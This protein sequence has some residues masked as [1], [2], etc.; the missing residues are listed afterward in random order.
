MNGREYVIYLDVFFLLN[1]IVAY[2]IILITSKIIRKTVNKS[3]ICLAAGLYGL[4]NVLILKPLFIHL[5]NTV[6]LNVI[7]AA[8]MV[9]IAF[10]YGEMKIYFR[11]LLMTI[12]VS[13]G[14]LGVIS[15]LYYFTVMGKYTR[16]VLCGSTNRVVNGRR[17]MI[18]SFM[19][20]ILLDIF[21][22]IVNRLRK[23]ESVYF[24]VKLTF[25]G[26]SVVA[27]ALYDT[28]NSLIEPVSKRDVHVAEYGLLKPIMEGD[29]QLEEK[30]CVIPFHSLG[31]ERG[32]MYGIRIDEMV[33]IYEGKPVFFNNPVIGIYKGSVSNTGKY[34][35][36]LNGNI[37]SKLKESRG[38]CNG[39]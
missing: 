23:N 27:K 8:V 29:E 17:F 13:A 39:S 32:L 22:K 14:F 2:M 38:D 37:D 26:K 36:I 6:L 7:A 35:V 24:D 18:S 20:Y 9:V 25:N 21:I 11:N 28:G 16:S 34:S 30:I 1:F 19:A 15:Y 33:V 4:Y 12:V 3:R 10:G 31:N 5:I